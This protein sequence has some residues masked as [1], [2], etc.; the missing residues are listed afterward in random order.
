MAS[1]EQ[2][3]LLIGSNSALTITTIPIS[4]QKHDTAET[5]SLDSQIIKQSHVINAMFGSLN[6]PAMVTKTVTTERYGQITKHLIGDARSSS[7]LAY[8]LAL[9]KVVESCNHFYVKAESIRSNN[10]ATQQHLLHG[11]LDSFDENIGNALSR[12]EESIECTGQGKVAVQTFLDESR[13]RYKSSRVARFQAIA[14][15]IVKSRWLFVPKAVSVLSMY[16]V[17]S[18]LRS[19]T[20]LMPGRPHSHDKPNTIIF[21]V[22][23]SLATIYLLEFFAMFYRDPTKGLTVVPINELIQNLEIL[24]HQFVQAAMMIKSFQKTIKHQSDFSAVEKDLNLL[25]D[26]CYKLQDGFPTC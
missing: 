4:F 8:T 19:Q 16:Y 25:R 11:V 3:P 9:Q 23:T 13:K 12:L 15:S 1:A 17:F 10:F 22:A 20:D 5:E 21:L 26:V 24:K 2:E 6:S 18:Q 14:L 7:R